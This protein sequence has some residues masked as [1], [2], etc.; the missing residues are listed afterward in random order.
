MRGKIRHYSVYLCDMVF[1]SRNNERFVFKFRKPFTRICLFPVPRTPE[2]KLQITPQ[3]LPSIPFLDHLQPIYLSFNTLYSELPRVS[4]NSPQV[5]ERIHLPFLYQSRLILPLNASD[6]RHAAASRRYFVTCLGRKLVQL[7]LEDIVGSFTRCRRSA[8][9]VNKRLQH[10]LSH[11]ADAELIQSRQLS[12]VTILKTF[13]GFYARL[14]KRS[15]DFSISFRLL[16]Y[17]KHRISVLAD[18]VMIVI[19]M[20]V[21]NLETYKRF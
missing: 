13:G 4:F 9:W 5:H 14:V 20:H 3:Y 12:F 21:P 17:L 1:E 6:G 10:A 8:C 19:I 7:W 15:K 2:Q 11:E 18:F 16:A